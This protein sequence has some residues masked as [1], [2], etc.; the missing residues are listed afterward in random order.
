MSERAKVVKS[1]EEVIEAIRNGY[2][3]ENKEFTNGR[4]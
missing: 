1:S 2:L 4:H 3:A